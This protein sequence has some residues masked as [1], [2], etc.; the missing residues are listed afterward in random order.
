[1]DVLHTDSYVSRHHAT[2]KVSNGEVY[3]KDVRSQNGTFINSVRVEPFTWTRVEASNVL[4]FGETI[5]PHFVLWSE[6]DVL[7]QSS[8]EPRRVINFS[9]AD[10]G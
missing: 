8:L 6:G 10:D 1:M 5:H 4:A 2:L 9:I 7:K 3:I